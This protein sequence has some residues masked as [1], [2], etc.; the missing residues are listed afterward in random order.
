MGSAFRTLLMVTALPIVT[1]VAQAYALSGELV[2]LDGEVTIIRETEIVDADF[3]MLVGQ[4]DSVATGTD[5]IAI[6]SLP[7]DIEI[8]LRENSRLAMDTLGEKTSVTLMNGGIFSK[9]ARGI[10]GG[11]TVKTEAAVAGVRGTEVF[12]AYGRKIDEH[13]DIWLCVNSGSVEV[14]I[15]AEEHTVVV[16]EGQGINI[17][18][19]VK[20]TKPRRYPWTTK[21][22]WNTDPAS[23][24]V[25]DRTDLEN[26]YSDLLNQDYD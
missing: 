1:T 15:L 13:S 17:V 25:V 5:S 19:G 4:G 8:K 3:G 6:I 12:V 26:A 16:E 20:L 9:V 11:Y 14:A 23:G 18:G 22:N 7:Q 2:Y 21:L 10:A 24:D